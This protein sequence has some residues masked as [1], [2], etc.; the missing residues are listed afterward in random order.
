MSSNTVSKSRYSSTVLSSGLRIVVEEI[1]SA[2][3]V[4]VGFFVE[5]GSRNEP[6]ELMGVSHFLE[7]MSF[8]A[9]K[10][11]SALEVNLALDDMGSHA[12]AY[13]SWE[14][15][16]FYAQ[17]LPEFMSSAVNLIAEMIDPAFL[18]SDF[19]CEKNVI[20]EEIEMYNDRPES[21]LFD[22]IMQA[23]FSP[24]PLSGRILGTRETIQNL[25]HEMMK[26]YHSERYHPSRIVLA[27]SGAVRAEDVETVAEKLALGSNKATTFSAGNNT[28]PK[29]KAKCSRIREG[30]MQEQFMAVWE[31]PS[32]KKHRALYIA[33]MLGILLG[34][35]E[36]SRL[37]WSLTHTGLVQS[38]EAGVVAFT[39][40]GLFYAGF[41][42]LPENFSKCREI[43]FDEIKRIKDKPPN[44]SEFER[45]KTKFASRTILSSESTQGRMMGIGVDELTR[46]PHLNL[47]EEL[48]LILSITSDEVNAFSST[49]NEAEVEGSIGPMQENL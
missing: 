31:G 11:R 40:T 2:A 4:A 34:D 18:V 19:D 38:I 45:A 16:V 13:T 9:T 22:E 21:L 3:S 1:P 49:L 15:T 42:S 10:K 32:Y 20:L 41:A 6:P 25:T 14:R 43:L 27:V 36:G 17:V 8:K 26:Q 48:K 35:E 12:N 29:N 47:E 24:H 46:Q 28:L 23:R 44:K 33:G 37:S 5:T 30:D 39:D 7:H